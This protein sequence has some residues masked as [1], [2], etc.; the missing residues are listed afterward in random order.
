MSYFYTEG[1][2]LILDISAREFRITKEVNSQ[3]FNFCSFLLYSAFQLFFEIV[4][5][6]AKCAHEVR[7]PERSSDPIKTSS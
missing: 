2:M 1:D 4:Y 6:R 5:Y 3:R 7:A